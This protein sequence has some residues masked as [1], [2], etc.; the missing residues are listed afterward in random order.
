MLKAV[1]KASRR[2]RAASKKPGGMGLLSLSPAR[3]FIRGIQQIK[4][5]VYEQT[6]I[7]IVIRQEGD[8]RA[9]AGRAPFVLRR[10]DAHGVRGADRLRA[11]RRRAARRISRRS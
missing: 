8:A 6:E 4:W 9:R 5:G 3:H 11:E 2:L 10:P 7:F 1:A